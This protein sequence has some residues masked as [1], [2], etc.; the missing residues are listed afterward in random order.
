MV[1]KPD[2]E[3]WIRLSDDVPHP[4]TVR[5]CL[6]KRREERHQPPPLAVELPDDKR[7]LTQAVRPHDLKEYDSLQDVME[8]K[9]N[10]K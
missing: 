2:L 10:E 1:W 5:L 6:E 4:N 8:D 7:L 3:D 9:E